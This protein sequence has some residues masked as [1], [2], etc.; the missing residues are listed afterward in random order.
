VGAPDEGG[1]VADYPDYLATVIIWFNGGFAAGRS[2]LAQE[3]QRRP[4]DAL[5]YDPEDVGLMLWKWMLPNDDFQ[6]LPSW[7]EPVVA[8]ALSL[9]QAPLA[10]AHRADV[11]SPR[12][13]PDGRSSAAWPTQARKFT[14]R[15]GAAA[16]TC[17]RCCAYWPSE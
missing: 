10:H 11:A 1:G 4:P 2:T 6:D 15:W 14:S 7:R 8:T 9:A 5:V 17:P 12:G 3:L 16:S 13:V